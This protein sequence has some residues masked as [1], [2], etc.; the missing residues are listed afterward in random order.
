MNV[1]FDY[2]FA[3]SMWINLGTEELIHDEQ[4]R[5]ISEKIQIVL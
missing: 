5:D 3:Q 2:S 4:E 1:L